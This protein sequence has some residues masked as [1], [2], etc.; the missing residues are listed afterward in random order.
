MP[1]S[2]SAAILFIAHCRSRW[3]LQRELV[4]PNR[5]SGLTGSSG[6]CDTAPHTFEGPTTLAAAVMAASARADDMNSRRFDPRSP[7]LADI[8][9]SFLDSGCWH[10]NGE[11][12]RLLQNIQRSRPW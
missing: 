1:C 9:P 4:L 10:I 11:R 12:Q 8:A 6:L 7:T 5:M 2:P 3:P